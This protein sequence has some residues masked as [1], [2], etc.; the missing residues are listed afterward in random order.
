MD[1]VSQSLEYFRVNKLL[2][3]LHLLELKRNVFLWLKLAR[4]AVKK[5]FMKN[6]VNH[7]IF[8]VRTTLLCLWDGCHFLG[9]SLLF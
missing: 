7:R 3:V 2:L 4:L 9:H 8:G 5:T 6:T 1:Q